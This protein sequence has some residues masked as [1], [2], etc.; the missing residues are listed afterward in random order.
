MALVHQP[1]HLVQVLLLGQF[2]APLHREYAAMNV[3]ILQ[4]QRDHRSNAIITDMKVAPLLLMCRQT[5]HL[6]LLK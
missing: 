4:I 1:V 2:T 3:T 6:S 5:E